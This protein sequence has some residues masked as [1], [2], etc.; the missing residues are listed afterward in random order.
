LAIVI[1][2]LAVKVKEADVYK[3]NNDKVERVGNAAFLL[4]II[5]ATLALVASVLGGLTSWLNRKL[6][7]GCVSL[8]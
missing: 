1:I 2:V 7:I 4:M 6:C 8:V 3:N 5:F